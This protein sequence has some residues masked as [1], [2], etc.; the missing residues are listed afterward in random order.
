RRG[1]DTAGGGSGSYESEF[2]EVVHGALG[3]DRVINWDEGGMSQEAMQ[4]DYEDWLRSSMEPE[5]QKVVDDTTAAA[6]EAIRGGAT[7]GRALADAVGISR[8]R[9]GKILKEMF[10]QGMLVKKGRGYELA[11]EADKGMTR[12]ADARRDEADQITQQLLEDAAE[13][14]EEFGR[15]GDSTTL[16]ERAARM[17]NDL[18][19]YGDLVRPDDP[20]QASAELASRVL[21]ELPPEA[22]TDEVIRQLGM[23]ETDV[24]IVREFMRQREN[25]RPVAGMATSLSPEKVDAVDAV[26]EGRTRLDKAMQGPTL[27]GLPEEVRL[28]YEEATR[29]G[30][31]D[32]AEQAWAVWRDLNPDAPER[33]LSSEIERHSAHLDRLNRDIVTHYPERQQ[34]AVTELSDLVGAIR[35]SDEWTGLLSLTGE[36]RAYLQRLNALWHGLTVKREVAVLPAGA[37]G[38]KRSTAAERRAKA[39]KILQMRREGEKGSVPVLAPAVIL[40]SPALAAYAVMRAGMRT[41]AKVM[42]HGLR[43]AARAIGAAKWPLTKLA[44]LW[45]GKTRIERLAGRYELRAATAESRNVGK[46]GEGRGIIDNQT[47]WGEI[48]LVM[49]YERAAFYSKIASEASARLNRVLQ[50]DSQFDHDFNRA[51]EILGTAKEKRQADD[52]RWIDDWSEKLT[53]EQRDVVDAVREMYGSIRQL[54]AGELLPTQQQRRRD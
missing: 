26:L 21:L 10:S 16:P 45:T 34:Q 51:L 31:E 22:R 25:P 40:V 32:A 44:D 2:G 9:A 50:E 36:G 20:Q 29:S 28:I 30:A 17:A 8:D 43:L 35:E 33:P 48:D 42:R 4:A 5:P 24:P 11:P 49:A 7:S 13:I 3:G 47:K 18:A 12:E 46:Y 41:M 53:E 19:D 38:R 37:G 6:I 1:D 54:V 23:G 39:E 27:E 15:T 52:A 14:A